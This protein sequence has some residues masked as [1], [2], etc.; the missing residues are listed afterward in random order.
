[1]HVPVARRPPSATARTAHAAARWLD[2]WRALRQGLGQG[3]RHL[4]SRPSVRP[5]APMMPSRAS[6]PMVPSRASPP[7]MPSRHIPRCMHTRH[8]GLGGPPRPERLNTPAGLWGSHCP[9]PCTRPLPYPDPPPSP[10]TASMLLLLAPPP[11]ALQ[12]PPP[13]CHLRMS[14]PSLQCAPDAPHPAGHFSG[15]EAPDAARIGGVCMRSRPRPPPSG[16]GGGGGEGEETTSVRCQCGTSCTP[17][18]A[19]SLDAPQA[20]LTPKYRIITCVSC[21]CYRIITCVSCCCITPKY[22]I[23]T[24][25]SCCC[26]NTATAGATTLAP[27]HPRPSEAVGLAHCWARA[28]RLGRDW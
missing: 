22:R 18:T 16:G 28:R 2:I 27:R 25:V 23:I 5:H 8:G 12:P 11:P 15:R 19:T 21:Y 3:P 10:L 26:C 20:V 1:M 17:G 6:P 24:C 14:P 13:I 4:P 9:L 7:M